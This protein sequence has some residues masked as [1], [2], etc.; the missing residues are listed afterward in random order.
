MGLWDE[1]V[2]PRLISAG[3]NAE[4]TRLRQRVCAQLAGD[5]VEIGFGSGLNL[6]HY[7]AQVGGVW[8]VEPS[9]V[10]WR[11]AQPRIVSRGV[12]VQRAGRDGQRMQLPDDRFDAALSTFTM[13]TIPDLDDALSEVRRVL[14]PGGVVHFVEHGRSD[15]PRIAKWQDR[16]QPVYGRLAAGCHIDRPIEVHLRRCGLVLEELETFA[17]GKQSPFN[18]VLIGRMRKAPI[19]AA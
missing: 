10:A 9:D 3:R 12:P 14:R 6:A 13:C 19:G 2:L 1:Q 7:P 5:I 8:A 11:L 17:L 15:S 18:H 16:L 4:V